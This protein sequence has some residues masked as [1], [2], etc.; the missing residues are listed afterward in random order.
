MS[1]QVYHALVGYDK[2]SERVVAE[3]ELPAHE[4]DHAK[5]VAG[6]GAD[7]PDAVMCYQLSPSQAADIA[8]AVGARLDTDALIFY[9]EGFD[10][11][12]NSAT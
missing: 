9:L 10:A 12:L 3:Y 11:P 1:T 4:L 6:V 8:G 5:R 2:I 7:D